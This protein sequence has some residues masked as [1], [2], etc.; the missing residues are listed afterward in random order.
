MKTAMKTDHFTLVQ[1]HAVKPMHLEMRFA[2]DVVLTVDINPL[3]LKHKSLSAL[4][5]WAVFNTAKLQDAGRTVQWSGNDELE[6]ASDN[7]RARAIEQSG[8][9]SHEWLWNWMHKHQLTLDAASSFLGISRRMLAYYKSGAK[10]LP[11]TVVL[12]CI[13]LESRNFEIEKLA[14]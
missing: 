5:D 8:Q 13:G 12:A 6:L 11:L 9:Y 14:A 2:D 10:P 1:L 3:A 7:L 4:S